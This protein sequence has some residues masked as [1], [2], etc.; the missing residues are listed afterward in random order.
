MKLR[1]LFLLS[2]IVF[3]SSAFSGGKTDKI[4]RILFVGNSLTYT[5]DLPA[6]VTEIGKLDGTTITYTSFLLPDYSLED[7]WNDGKAKAEIDKGGYDYVVAQQGP[8]A[9]AESQSLLLE[10]AKKFADVCK[11]NK[12]KLALFMVWPS[13][14]RS[15]DHDNVIISYTNAADKTSSILCPAGLAWKYAWQLQPELPLYSPDNFH[16]GVAGS[17][18]AAFIIYGALAEKKDF[19]FVKYDNCSWKNEITNERL[20]ILEQAA[21]KALNK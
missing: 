11:K 8:S 15:V 7:H 13:K 20:N 2:L 5:N 21:L 9:L 10:Y 4:L 18:L 1:N 12:S 17:V 19:D 6:L 14:A 16:P 3:C